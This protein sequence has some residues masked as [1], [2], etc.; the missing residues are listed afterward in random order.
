MYW[1]MVRVREGIRRVSPGQ[2][3]FST[4]GRVRKSLGQLGI[5]ALIRVRKRN[6]VRVR[7]RKGVRVRVRVS[8]VKGRRGGRGV[9]VRVSGRVRVR[10]RRKGWGSQF[11]PRGLSQTG[12]RGVSGPG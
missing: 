3:S 8:R 5:P 10:V 12:G 9:K 6:R 7:V 1:W 11:S 4:Q 2:V